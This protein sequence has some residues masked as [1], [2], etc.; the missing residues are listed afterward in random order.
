[1]RPFQ[2]LIAFFFG[3]LVVFFEFQPFKESGIFSGLFDSLPFWVL[4][5]LIILFLAINFRQYSNKRQIISLLPL[6][7]C[8]LSLSA[9]LWHQNMREKLDD[10]PT[11]FKATT[12]DIGNDGGLLF[13]FKKNGHV[14][15]EKRDHFSVTYY[16]G[17]YSQHQDTIHLDIPLD[18]KLARQALLTDDSLHFVGDTA[19]FIVFR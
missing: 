2:I 1:M 6:T 17:K 8:V 9:T 15:A 3:G 12:Y 11:N 16:W 10:S 4:C 18:F 7:I 13:D 14:K 19:K 5:V